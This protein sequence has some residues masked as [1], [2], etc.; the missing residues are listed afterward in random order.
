[1]NFELE[2]YQIN[3]QQ[4]VQAFAEKAFEPDTAM[5]EAAGTFTR[6]EWR[7]MAINSLCA[8]IAP[9]KFG[10]PEFSAFETALALEAFAMG[11]SDGG[12]G[13]S[14]GAHL[15]AGLLPVLRYT[16][17]EQLEG[18]MRQIIAG[19]GIVACA[20]TEATSGSDAFRMKTTAT[21]TDSGYILQGE[22][23]FCTNAPIADYFLVY[24]LTDTEKGFFGGISAFLVPKEVTG[25][26]IGILE[27][28]AGLHSSPLATVY[29]NQVHV[30]TTALIGKEGGGVRI[31]H[32]A[33]DWERILL[34]AL[35]V[36]AMK[37][38]CK[39]TVVYAHTR[40]SGNKPIGEH[41]AVAFR[42]ADMHMQTETAMLMVYQAAKL[43]SENKSVSTKASQTKIMVSEAYE[44][45][46][47]N[48]QLVFGAA[49]YIESSGI[50]AAI[51]NAQ[52]AA[53]YSGT[54]DI[55]R[56]LIASKL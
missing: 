52:A 35:H 56:L 23:H 28:K 41:Q 49:G 27:K 39:K 43:L 54:N 38:I 14:L 24:A 16:D 25:L 15:S 34:S 13:F 1:M 46:A 2:P 47:R 30:P 31:F 3:L 5:R 32:E 45:V 12:L 4:S 8:C 33:M 20:L 36:G 19:E 6:D 9:V 11:C 22:K 44:Q 53:I 26:E 18:L 10:G 7:K 51:R 17:D 40:T 37:R 48:A 55:Q 42:I 21:K 29:L 50:P